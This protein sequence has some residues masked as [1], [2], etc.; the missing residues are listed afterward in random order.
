MHYNSKFQSWLLHCILFVGD[1]GRRPQLKRP[2]S[3]VL[4]S[5]SSPGSKLGDCS[6]HQHITETQL[7]WFLNFSFFSI[8]TRATKFGLSIFLHFFPDTFHLISHSFLKINCSL[9][10]CFVWSSNVDAIGIIHIIFSS[11]F[12][13]RLWSHKMVWTEIVGIPIICSSAAEQQA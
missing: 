9:N 11:K 10:C 7:V 4:A 6:V 5:C 1:L 8:S 3:K 12:Q 13:S 2:K